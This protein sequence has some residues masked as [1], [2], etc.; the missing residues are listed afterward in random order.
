[1]ARTFCHFQAGS[2]AINQGILRIPSASKCEA[3]CPEPIPNIMTFCSAFCG[4]SSVVAQV[5]LGWPDKIWRPFVTLHFTFWANKILSIFIVFEDLIRI[6]IHQSYVRIFQ[7]DKR[8]ENIIYCHH[9]LQSR[10]LLLHHHIWHKQQSFRLQPLNCFGF[11]HAYNV[12]TI[13]HSLRETRETDQKLVL[14][15][16]SFPR[17]NQHL[18][19]FREDYLVII[20]NQILLFYCYMGSFIHCCLQF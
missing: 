11:L 4:S 12:A 6:Y 10:G 17:N 13:H 2:F 7:F 9:L 15:F 16:H 19:G 8:K 14:R 3:P 20:E 1:M 18:P 5:R